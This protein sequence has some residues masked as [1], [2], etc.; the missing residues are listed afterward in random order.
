MQPFEQMELM[1]S[2][3]ERLLVTKCVYCGSKPTGLFFSFFLFTTSLY[4]F[5]HAMVLI[6]IP[7]YSPFNILSNGMFYHPTNT[8]LY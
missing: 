5:M 3:H 1:C 7:N 4:T 6:Y 2:D 8:F